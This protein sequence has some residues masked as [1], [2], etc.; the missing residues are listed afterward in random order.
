M[1]GWYNTGDVCTVDKEG[2]VSFVGRTKNMIKNKG[3]QVSSAEL[4][5]YLN[6][7]PHVIEG[8]L[9][10]T[11]DES[12]LTELPTAWVI[13]KDHFKTVKQRK[14]ALRDIHFA[15]NKE[16]SGYKKLRGG[17]WQISRLPKNATGK[18]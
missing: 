14:Q 4:E 2:M 17:E 15:V 10:P 3:F 5:G 7:H 16:V 11:W 8:G 13:L 18:I 1:P 6:T 12:Q 9:G